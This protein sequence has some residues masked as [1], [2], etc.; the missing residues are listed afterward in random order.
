MT[1]ENVY[2]PEAIRTST[3][4]VSA[5]QILESF[6]SL[7]CALQG[8]LLRSQQLR[9]LVPDKHNVMCVTGSPELF[10]AVRNAVS[11]SS[12]SEAS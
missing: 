8:Q 1:A 6:H 3:C 5:R 10:V 7:S 2:E 4:P 9:D 11:F 12:Q